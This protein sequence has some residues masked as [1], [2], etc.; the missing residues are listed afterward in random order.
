M[1]E[2]PVGRPSPRRGHEAS[3]GRKGSLPRQRK[4]SPRRRG[5]PRRGNVSLGEPEDGSFE[6]FGLHKQGFACLG[7]PLHLGEGRLRL[8]ELVTTLRPVFMA[9]LGSILGPGF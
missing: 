4:C 3:L 7:K 1:F 8:G 9:C 5:P 2:F 6:V